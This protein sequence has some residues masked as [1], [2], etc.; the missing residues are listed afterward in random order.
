M[1]N[2]TQELVPCPDTPNPIGKKWAQKIK[3]KYDG[4]L[5]K[6][7]TRLVSKGYHQVESI[8]YT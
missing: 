4:L 7:K 5:D 2:R 6:Y 1:D 3:L 8:D